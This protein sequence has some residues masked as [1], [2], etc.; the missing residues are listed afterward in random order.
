MLPELER[1][2]AVFARV[3]AVS[4]LPF[5]I[6]LRCNR[7]RLEYVEDSVDEFAAVAVAE[8]AFAVESA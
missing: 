8:E 7:I 3:A 2:E 4:R 1:P 5:D 6:L